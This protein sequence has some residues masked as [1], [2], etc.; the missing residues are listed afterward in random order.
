ME[1][2][3]G[4]S[5]DADDAF[6]FYGIATGLI[7]TDPITY[8]HI[9]TDIENLNRLALKGQLDVTAA[10]V[11]ACAYLAQK[12]E[13]LP[14]GASMGDGYGPILVAQRS[15]SF[16]EISRL[17]VAV[18]GTLTSAYLALRLAVGPTPFTVMP[19]DQI[20]PAVA[21]GTV[22]LGLLIHEG[23][24]TYEELGLVKVGDLGKW[25]KEKTGLP[26]PLGVNLVRRDLFE[27][28]KALVAKHLTESIKMAFQRR[29]ESLRYAQGFGRGLNR[30]R[31]E[32]FVGLYVSDLTLHMGEVGRQAIRAFLLEGARAGLVPYSPVS[33]WCD[34]R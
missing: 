7:P 15:F 23:Q 12:Y 11:H 2:R 16:S 25:W 32:S 13:I 30:E 29:E 10:S 19:F 17:K 22:P 20:L 34:E 28:V 1:I 9:V 33:F 14:V 5:P 3:I 21:A 27:E 8:R 31:T 4:H 18:P 26:L 6:M 24:L